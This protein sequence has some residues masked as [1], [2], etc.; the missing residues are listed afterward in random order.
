MMQIVEIFPR[1][2]Q[3]HPDSKVHG[4]DMGPIWDQQDSGRPN[5]GPVNF[6]I[7]SCLFYTINIM[8][9]H[10]IERPRARVSATIT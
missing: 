10:V 3:D 4:A 2:W 7:W 8:P 6:A 9:P 5:V 1:A